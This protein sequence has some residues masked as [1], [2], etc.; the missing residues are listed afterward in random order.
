MVFDSLKVLWT[1]YG[2]HYNSEYFEDPSIFNPRRFEEPVPPYAFLAFGGGPRVCAGY[3]LAKLNILIFVHF[4]V[5]RYDWSLL[6]PDEPITMD[7]LP[8]PS[9]GMPIKITPKLF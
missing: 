9:H 3:Q 5:T 8:F 1:T 7:P 4:I 6:Y 2:T